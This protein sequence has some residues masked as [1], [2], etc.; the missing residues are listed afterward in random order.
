MNQNIFRDTLTLSHIPTFWCWVLEKSIILQKIPLLYFSALW[1]IFYWPDKI[2][3]VLQTIPEKTQYL[4]SKNP[5]SFVSRLW[6]ESN[7]A[8]CCI[9][10]FGELLFL[11]VPKRLDNSTVFNYPELCKQNGRNYVPSIL[12]LGFEY[13]E[14]HTTTIAFVI[15]WSISSWSHKRCCY[16]ELRA[17]VLCRSAHGYQILSVLRLTQFPKWGIQ[18]LQ[19]CNAVTCLLPAERPY[20]TSKKSAVLGLV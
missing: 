14:K 12:T 4:Y 6:L 19:I 3:A 2:T 7:E 5:P 15:S 9:V 10:E 20:W 13:G 8:V 16:L 18:S 17:N 1:K 11:Q